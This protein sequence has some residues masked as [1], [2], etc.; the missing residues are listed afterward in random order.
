MQDK[1]SFGK[2]ISE[3]RKDVNLTQEDRKKN[4]QNDKDDEVINF[5]VN[6]CSK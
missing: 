3:K 6:N 4:P 5:I 2:Y 1:E